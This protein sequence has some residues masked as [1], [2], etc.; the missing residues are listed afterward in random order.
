MDEKE[1]KWEDPIVA[2]IH[3]VRKALVEECDNDPQAVFNYFL[4]KQKE[5]EQQGR[6]YVTRPSKPLDHPRTGTNN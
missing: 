6:T 4:Q 3:A 2:A 1:K 5:G